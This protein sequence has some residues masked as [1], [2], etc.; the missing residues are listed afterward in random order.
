MYR[1]QITCWIHSI[2][3]AAQVIDHQTTQLHRSSQHFFPTQDSPS[4][5]KKTRDTG[6]NE[7]MF[8]TRSTTTYSSLI[9][10]D[11]LFHIQLT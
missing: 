5:T 11:S 7:D 4:S 6:S 9:S 10:H 3:E 8:V 1:D 2:G